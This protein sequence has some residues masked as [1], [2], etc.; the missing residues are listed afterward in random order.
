MTGR[1]GDG[2]EGAVLAS[3]PLFSSLLEEKDCVS[4][5][6]PGMVA[7][8]VSELL[9]PLERVCALLP[10]AKSC[11]EIRKLP[12]DEF[13]GALEVDEADLDRL[14][15]FGSQSRDFFGLRWFDDVDAAVLLLPLLAL[16]AI[17]FCCCSR[18]GE[19]AIAGWLLVCSSRV[20]LREI[21]CVYLR[22]Q[23]WRL[24]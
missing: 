6:E 7:R 3:P 15:L 1:P 10:D 16:E 21:A 18:A 8:G 20:G 4:L 22:L 13:E 24:V 23:Y 11:R 2:C 5:G 12:R 9:E 14:K 19:P 17:M